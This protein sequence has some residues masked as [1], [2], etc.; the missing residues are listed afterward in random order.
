[1]SKAE[2]EKLIA[3]V[4]KQMRKAAAD[5]DFEAAADLRDQMLE[6]KEH[7]VES[8]PMTRNKHRKNT[9]K[10]IERKTK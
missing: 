6:L 10:R 4:E 8:D 5:L 7:L 3:K 9:K 2:I 1:M